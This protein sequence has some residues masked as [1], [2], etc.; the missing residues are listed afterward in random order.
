VH[1]GTRS[2]RRNTLVIS[3]PNASATFC[4]TIFEQSQ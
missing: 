1:Q 2:H 3:S 4:R